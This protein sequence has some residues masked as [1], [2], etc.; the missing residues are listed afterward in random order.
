MR[1]MD[2]YKEENTIRESRSEKNKELYQNSNKYTN[3][4]DVTNA[5]VY[6]INNKHFEN[7]EKTRKK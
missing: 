6:E 3:I 2:R 7:K 1:R 5:N 4:T